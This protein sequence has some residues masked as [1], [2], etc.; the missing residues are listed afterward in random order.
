MSYTLV[1][2]KEKNYTLAKNICLI[3]FGAI[4]LGIF[5]KIYIPLFFTPVPIG[6]QNSI[7]VSYGFFYK[8][9]KAALSIFLFVFLGCMGLPFF[10][11]GSYGLLH[12]LSST[13]GYIIGYIIAAFF[14]G[15]IF[16]KIKIFSLKN[17][18][19]TILFGHL[20]VLVMGWLWFSTIV[21]MKTAFV[22]GVLPFIAGDVFKS[23]VITKL[24]KYL[25]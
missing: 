8:S 13:G 25:N 1:E 23:I 12:L 16:E 17:I 20:I 22:L 14:V 9:K 3:I 21:G 7:A 11:H 4:F 10:S 24:I 15:R 19:L 6:L 18:S 5:S 2:G